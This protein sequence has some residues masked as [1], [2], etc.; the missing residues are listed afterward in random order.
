MEEVNEVVSQIVPEVVV[1]PKKDVSIQTDKKPASQKQ[2]DALAR[3]RALNLQ[4][5][6]NY[7]EFEKMQK[8]MQVH[9]EPVHYAE[10]AQK[11]QQNVYKLSFV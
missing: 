8:I 1:I 11:V 2:L 5:K 9:N 7:I 4:R 10:P 3:G 6:K